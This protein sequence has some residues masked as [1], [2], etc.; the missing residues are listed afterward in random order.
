MC[1]FL[2]KVHKFKV[3]GE[4]KCSVKIALKSFKNTFF[5]EHLW[6]LAIFVFVYLKVPEPRA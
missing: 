4:K 3:R 2:R 5:I 1:T 6:W